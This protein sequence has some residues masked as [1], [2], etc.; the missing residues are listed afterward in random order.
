MEKED[1]KMSICPKDAFEASMQVKNNLLNEK[2]D[3]IIKVIEKDLCTKYFGDP[4]LI[5][6][7]GEIN[8]EVIDLVQKHFADYW[9]VRFDG[10]KNIGGCNF[11]YFII[12]EKKNNE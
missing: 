6:R 1:F 9:N 7:H 2:S 3:E 12:S 10:I 8:K 11:S 4:I 5:S